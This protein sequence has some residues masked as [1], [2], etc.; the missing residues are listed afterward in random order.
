MLAKATPQASSF[1]PYAAASEGPIA[2]LAS[3]NKGTAAGEVVLTDGRCNRRAGGSSSGS[4][5]APAAPST[6]PKLSKQ[7]VEALV[8]ADAGEEGHISPLSKIRP[9]AAVWLGFFPR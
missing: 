8:K 3:S 1:N 9:C 4:S 7:Q 2:S 6:P 5:K